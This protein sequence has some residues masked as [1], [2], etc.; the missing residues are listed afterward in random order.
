M[1][2]L[3]NLAHLVLPKHLQLL[4][5]VLLKVL[6]TELRLL[7]LRQSRR[8]GARRLPLNLAALWWRGLRTST[9]RRRGL[10]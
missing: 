8:I 2:D 4:L 6:V 3:L 10:V 7:L 5:V 1:F 9:K